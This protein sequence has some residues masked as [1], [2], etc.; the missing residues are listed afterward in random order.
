MT[1]INT[2]RELMSL[3][4]RNRDGSFSTQAA[5]RDILSMVGRQLGVFAQTELKFHR[6]D[7]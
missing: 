5:R 7:K 6:I 3:C 2:E 1:K 4:N